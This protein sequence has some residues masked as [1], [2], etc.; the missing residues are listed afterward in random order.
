MSYLVTGRMKLFP[1]L[2]LHSFSSEVK[3]IPLNQVI[4]TLMQVYIV[5]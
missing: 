4:S 5:A 2:D 1:A 3:L